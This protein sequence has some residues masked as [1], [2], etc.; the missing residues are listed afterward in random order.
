MRARARVDLATARLAQRGTDAEQAPHSSRRLRERVED[1][2]GLDRVTVIVNAAHAE[3]RKFARRAGTL[4]Q[5]LAAAFPQAPIL[6]RSW[7]GAERWAPRV[8][9]PMGLEA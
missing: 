5:L 1:S 3:P 6:A 4:D 7:V 2:V 8:L 9:V